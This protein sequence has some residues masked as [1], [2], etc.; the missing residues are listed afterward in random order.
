METEKPHKPTSLEEI[1]ELNPNAKEVTALHDGFKKLILEKG[2]NQ[3]I[4]PLL[5]RSK[6]RVLSQEMKI[7]DKSIR[8]AA[9]MSGNGK[10][11]KQ[12]I[13]VDIGMRTSRNERVYLVLSARSRAWWE[14]D[15]QTESPTR[16]D[17]NIFSEALS[18]MQKPSGK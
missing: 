11:E 14:P 1:A 6:V 4:G 9:W 13:N 12:N 3:K 7:K 5:F 18:L 10:P 17:L 15:F 8:V 2:T 16:E